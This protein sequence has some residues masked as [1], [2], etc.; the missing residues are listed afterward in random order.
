M[1]IRGSDYISTH[2]LWVLKAIE[3]IVTPSTI[4]EIEAAVFRIYPNF[5]FML[6]EKPTKQSVAERVALLKKIGY[7]EEVESADLNLRPGRKYAITNKGRLR[8]HP[9]N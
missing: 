9:K 3:I 1:D 6:V 7:V 2:T 8:L 4:D 5:K